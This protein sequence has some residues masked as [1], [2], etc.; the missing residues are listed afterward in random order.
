MLLHLV[1]FAASALSAQ[2]GTSLPAEVLYMETNQLPAKASSGPM[3]QRRARHHDTDTGMG[4]P[5]CKRPRT[6]ASAAVSDSSS[7]DR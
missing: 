6:T 5:Q 1:R 3:P 4:E 7:I 2:L